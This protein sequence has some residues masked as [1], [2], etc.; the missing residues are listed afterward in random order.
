M[1]EP[2]TDPAVELVPLTL[3][4]A[5][6]M[7]DVESLAHRLG[8]DVVATTSGSAVCRPR[9][10]LR[11]SSPATSCWPSTAGPLSATKPTCSPPQSSNVLPAGASLRS[12]VC[13]RSRRC[14]S[15]AD[16]PDWKPAR[17][18]PASGIS[19]QHRAPTVTG[20]PP[21]RVYLVHPAGA[22]RLTPGLRLR[23]ELAQLVGDDKVLRRS[24]RR[25][26][27]GARRRRTGPVDHE[28]K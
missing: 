25:A 4:A 8:D 21:R 20:D 17:I 12:R 27:G 28:R 18:S 5:E 14:S 26:C 2:T 23:V 1:T 13:P 9:S 6:L 19:R 16:D 10:R 11:R 24:F 3:L 22:K 7:E 15:N